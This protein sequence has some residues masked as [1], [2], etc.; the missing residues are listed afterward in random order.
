MKVRMLTALTG[1]TYSLTVGDEADFPDDEA[2][3]LVEAGFAA[4]VE[5]AKSETAAKKPA[6]ETRAN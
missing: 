2:I 4:P 6:A 1:P 5:K 3:R